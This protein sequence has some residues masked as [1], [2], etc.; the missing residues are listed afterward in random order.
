MLIIIFIYFII[1]YLSFS[2]NQRKIFKICIT[3]LRLLFLLNTDSSMNY[4]DI[5]LRSTTLLIPCKNNIKFDNITEIS[6]NN[7]YLLKYNFKLLNNGF[8]KIYWNTIFEEN[9]INTPKLI[10]YNYLDETY[11]NYYDS[12]KYY[13]KKPIFGSRGINIEKIKG[14]EINNILKDKNILIQELLVDCM[15]NSARHFRFVSLYNGTKLS[16]C[17]S[18]NNNKNEIV[19][20]HAAG[21]VQ[22]ACLNFICNNLSQIEQNKINNMINKLSLLHKQKFSDVFS[23]GWD[24]M[25]NCDFSNNIEI[26]CLEGNFLHGYTMEPEIT[27]IELINVLN[28]ELKIFFKKINI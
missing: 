6:Y 7:L 18:K 16:L 26:Y 27:P 9:N 22:S 23:I 5:I 2:E 25:F 11:I 15:A 1:L 21:G 17:E 20:N 14:D 13:L 28:K 3:H 10:A 8:D 24:L 4:S 19:S 12:N